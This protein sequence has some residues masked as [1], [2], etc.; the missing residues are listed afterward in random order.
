MVSCFLALTVLASA[1]PIDTSLAARYFQEASWISSD[2]GGALWGKPLGG[3]MIFVDPE[4]RETVANQAPDDSGFESKGTVFVGKLSDQI[5]LANT[6]FDWRGKRWSMILW[7]LPTERAERSRLMM[8]ELFH[9]IQPELGI[10]LSAPQNAHMET[11]DGRLWLQ[12]EL[13]ALSEA[14][15]ATVLETREQKA[16]DALAFRSLRQSLFPDAKKEEDQLEINEGLAEY[17]GTMLRGVSETESR[18]W[19]GNELRKADGLPAYARRFAYFTGPAY[20]L[21]I[22]AAEFDR[23]NSVT[24]RAKDRSSL[25]LPTILSELLGTKPLTKEVGIG[26]AK[27]YG[28]DSL[29]A[30]E[31]GAEQK[32]LDLILSIRR[33]LIEGAVL[34]LDLRKMNISYNP[35]NV[36]PLGKEGTYYPSATLID[37]WG[38]IEISDGV[39]I[40]NDFQTAWVD[41]PTGSSLENSGWK[42]KL[43]PGWKLVV[44]RGKG[45]FVLEK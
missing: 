32:R 43:Q 10:L 37:E 39:I 33:R 3:P 30:A 24:W 35:Q 17:T 23:T 42:L 13:R 34:R 9:R 7:P 12:L 40:A 14:L 5:G 2:D 29:L 44:G 6:A 19:L 45:D 26:I 25:C 15:S 4:T 28:Y 38:T 41:A 16:R 8:H 1:G 27:T 22:D 31:N 11:K 21:L 18:L 36:I 20:G